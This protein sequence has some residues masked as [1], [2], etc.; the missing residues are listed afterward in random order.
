MQAPAAG[1][2]DERLP[3]GHEQLL[4]Q[5]EGARPD[6]AHEQEGQQSGNLAARHRLHMGP[7]DQVGRAGE[8]PSALLGERPAHAADHTERRAG[9]HHSGGKYIMWLRH[10]DSFTAFFIA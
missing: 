9:E 8:E 2:A 3:A 1:R 4:Q 7:A 6:A 5:A 10:C